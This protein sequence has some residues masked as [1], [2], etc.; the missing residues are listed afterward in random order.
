MHYTVAADGDVVRHLAETAPGNHPQAI[1][2]RVAGDCDAA[3]TAATQLAALRVLLLDIKLRYPDIRLGGHRQVRGETTTCP[4]N[5]FPLQ[6]L[7]DWSMSGL[8]AER[9][10]ALERLIERQYGP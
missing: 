1:G 10:A 5:K 8:L 3:P 6:A 9:D 4:G 2:V 7:R